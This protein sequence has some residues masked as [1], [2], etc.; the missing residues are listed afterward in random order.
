VSPLHRIIYPTAIAALFVIAGSVPAHAQGKLDVRYGI[1]VAGISVGKGAWTVD[2]GTDQYS[3]S[4]SGSASGVASAIVNGEGTVSVNGALK[5]GRPVPATFV[6]SVKQ[7]SDKTEL[8]MTLDGGAVKEVK[9]DAEPPAAPDRVAVTDAHRKGVIDPLSA[10]LIPA[11]ATGDIV[12]ADACARTLPIFDG[13]RRFDL[14]L[15]FKRID[16]VKADKGYAGPVAVCAVTFQ[17]QAGHRPSST[18][19]KYLS[20]G[21]EI[22]LALAPVS[23]TRL[24]APFK[25]TIVNMLGNLV[26]QAT[27]FEVLKQTAPK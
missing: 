13:R 16:N 1:S 19:V 25:L 9:V 10:L 17:P 20:E 27:Q 24:L 4:A 8:K 12:T 6:S 5:D 21:R 3:M 18:L 14:K 15:S 11:A 7:D 23:G 22:E 26:V 2:L